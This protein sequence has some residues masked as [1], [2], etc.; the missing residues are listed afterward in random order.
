MEQ[1]DTRHPGKTG[2]YGWLHLLWVYLCVEWRFVSWRMRLWLHPEQRE[3]IQTRMK[4]TLLIVRH[5]QT[6]WN[7]EHRLPGQLPGVAL[8]E[9][10]RQQAARLAQALQV[11]PLSAIIS[12][13]LERAYNTA[14]YLAQG[15]ILK[16]SRNPI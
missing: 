1:Q 14:E 12:S 8:N 2:L 13:P 5:G 11:L 3:S 15:E 9:T 4:Q 6:T 7:V 16:S 10:G